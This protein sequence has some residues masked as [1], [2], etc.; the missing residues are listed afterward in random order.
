MPGCNGRSFTLQSPKT[1]SPG[2]AGCDW[3]WDLSHCIYHSALKALSIMATWR[4][5]I[6]KA[7][8]TKRVLSGLGSRNK[9][10]ISACSDEKCCFLHL[11]KCFSYVLADRFKSI[12]GRD[13]GSMEQF[14]GKSLS[15]IC[16]FLVETWVNWSTYFGTWWKTKGLWQMQV[17]CLNCTPLS[18]KES[19]IVLKFKCP[20]TNREI[21]SRS[22]KAEV[23]M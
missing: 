15:V 8:I 19:R 2:R 10:S 17:G 21:V 18:F 9:W 4:R 7:E 22:G 5:E 12:D 13:V 1:R 16:Q 6:S 23:W 20:L 11:A 3:R 14:W